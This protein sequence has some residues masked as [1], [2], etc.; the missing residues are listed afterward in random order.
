MGESIKEVFAGGRVRLKYQPRV[1]DISFAIGKKSKPGITYF[2]SM[3]SSSYSSCRVFLDGGFVETRGF[4]CDSSC[5]M[6]IHGN[7]AKAY[8]LYKLGF[9]ARKM[10]RDLSLPSL[11]DL[12]EKISD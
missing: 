1:R 12:E 3:V 5:G 7:L 4:F 6:F 10:M 8:I 2:G 11:V 9:D